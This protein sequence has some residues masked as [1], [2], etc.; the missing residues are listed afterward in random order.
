[1]STRREG[2][3]ARWSAARDETD[4][5]RTGG[6]GSGGD[7]LD[8]KGTEADACPAGEAVTGG[9]EEAEVDAM[10]VVGSA[11]VGGGV[12]S[13]R[14]TVFVAGESPTLSPSELSASAGVPR[15]GGVTVG[16]LSL[17]PRRGNTIAGA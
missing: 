17:L 14:E 16:L 15:R 8:G 9:E 10:G 6:E 1:M 12:V 11:G 2:D 5:R 13:S 7:G 3:P 4:S